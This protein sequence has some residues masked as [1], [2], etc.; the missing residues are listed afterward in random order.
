[1]DPNLPVGASSV[2]LMIALGVERG[3]TPAECLRGTGVRLE[4]LRDP[5]AEVTIKQEYAVMRNVLGHSGIEPGFAVALGSRYHIGMH[6]MWG[7]L[8]ATGSTLRESLTIALRYID[9]AWAFTT[10]E[11]SEADGVAV[12]TILG[13]DIPL[14]VRPFL[15][16]R[17]SGAARVMMRDVLGVDVALDSVR[18]QHSRPADISRYVEVFGLEPIFDASD[19][20]IRFAAGLLDAPLPQSNEWAR[21][22]FE[23]VCR[24]VLAK[25]RARTGVAGA[26][27]DL[28]VREP[29]RIPDAVTVAQELN[30]SR[31]TLFRRLDDE[32]TSFRALVDE[33]RETLAEEMLCTAGLTTEQVARR[34]GYLE[35][36]SFVRAFKRWKGQTPQEFRNAVTAR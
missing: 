35:P 15:V 33:V 18:F 12:L 11:L 2:Q 14:D 32:G 31:R 34:L 16:E 6:G 13:G 25:R 20:S 4:A 9:L 3:V 30:L 29:G 36:A 5:L 27:R 8:I 28:L 21:R 19:N 22:G 23:V 17:I 26:V 24:E 10:V 7:L 1:M